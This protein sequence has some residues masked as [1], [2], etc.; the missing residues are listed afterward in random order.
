MKWLVAY[1]ATSVAQ[2]FIQCFI[3]ESEGNWTCIE[4]CEIALAGGRIQFSVG[5]QFAGG[6]KFMDVDVAAL[7][8]RE[9]LK[10][11]SN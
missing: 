4:A 5:A 9:Y 3:R 6:T 1:V 10:T 11:H 2:N 7:L 8:D